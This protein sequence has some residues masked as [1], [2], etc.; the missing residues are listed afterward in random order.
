MLRSKTLNTVILIVI[1]AAVLGI[2]YQFS[3]SGDQHN[4]Q[5][6]F[7][8][9][10]RHIDIRTDNASVELVSTK[11]DR[12]TVSYTG[13]VPRTT[14]LN[15]VAHVKGD[16]LVVELTK[17]RRFLS[18]FSPFSQLHLT[19]NVP[20]DIYGSIRIKDKNGKIIMSDIEAQDIDL[21]TNNGKVEVARTDATSLNVKS[22][23]GRI[24]L[25]QVEGDITA[26]TNNGSI[27]L[28]TKDLDHRIDL[29]SN[30]GKII[31]NTLN[32]PNNATIQA[33][34]NNGKISVFG[35]HNQSTTF[36]GG[37]H[38][39]TLRTNNGSITVSR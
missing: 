13:K 12:T 22:N 10:Y 37:E 21:D 28:S 2:Y 16:T 23:N 35:H 19:V 24:I 38:M 7:N 20:E 25:E 6:S 15:F 4:D 32:E 31:I 11:Q 17:K 27:A 30:N 8:H 33:R 26:R 29:R 39:I 36:G 5:T 14:K 3:F 34:T 18:L 9:S 1:F